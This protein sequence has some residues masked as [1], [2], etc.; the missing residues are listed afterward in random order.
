M[1]KEVSFIRFAVIT[2]AVGRGGAVVRLI[3]AELVGPVE[4]TAVTIRT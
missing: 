1:E 4:S 2:A 3:G